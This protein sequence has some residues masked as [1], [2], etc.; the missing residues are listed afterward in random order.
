[1]HVIAHTELRQLLGYFLFFYHVVPWDRTQIVRF[2]GK[3][4]CL[5]SRLADQLMKNTSVR[6]LLLAELAFSLSSLVFCVFLAR[7]SWWWC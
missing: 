4:F 6:N 7:L 5:L 3:N 1:M 2:G